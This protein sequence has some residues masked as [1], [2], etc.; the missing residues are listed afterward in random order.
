M[1]DTATMGALMRDRLIGPIRDNWHAGMVLLFG[2]QTDPSGNDADG[3]PI[4]FKGILANA[5]NI[6]NTAGM[7]R[8]PWRA[9]RAESV[10]FRS[11]HEVLP[12]PDSEKFTYLTEPLRYGYALFNITGQLLRAGESSEASFE[13]A[14]KTS[15]TS[16]LGASKRDFN[17]AAFGDGSGKM[18][19]RVSGGTTAAATVTVDTTINFRTGEVIDWVETNTGAP[20]TNNTAFRVV[21]IDRANKV[22]TMDRNFGTNLTANSVAVRAS[23]DSTSTTPNNSYAKEIQGLA[24]LVGTGLLHGMN[25]ATYPLWKSYVDNASTFAAGAVL[26]DKILRNAKDQV[27]FESGLDLAGGNGLDFAILTTRGVRSR[28]SDTLL[29]LKRFNDVG[30]VKLHGGF[31]ALMFDENPIFTEDMCPP[32][33]VYGIAMNRLF[34]AQASDWEWMQEDGKVLKWESRRDRYVAVLYKY[35]NLGTTQ[36]NAHFKIQQLADDVR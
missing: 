28:Y 33:T 18:A 22:L 17:R 15:M 2:T 29:P 9:N 4:G 13:S 20:L 5:E 6:D 27:G 23:L 26:N 36:R 34:W 7:F 3:N 35:C 24:S 10:G 8:I 12:A 30:S 16:T 32:G 1:A 14:F 21:A 19:A 25:P 11:E 31:T